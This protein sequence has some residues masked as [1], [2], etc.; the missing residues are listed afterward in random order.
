[1]IRQRFFRLFT[2]LAGKCRV[3]GA[4]AVHQHHDQ[5]LRGLVCG[6]CKDHVQSAELQLFA[7]LGSDGIPVGKLGRLAL[8]EDGR[9]WNSRKEPQN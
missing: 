7:W 9:F 4:R 5:D 6:E 3:C 2:P 8:R 1:M